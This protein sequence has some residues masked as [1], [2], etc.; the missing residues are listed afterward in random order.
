MANPR[1]IAVRE[2]EAGGALTAGREVRRDARA[3][4]SALGSDEGLGCSSSGLSGAR[5][6][7]AP[8]LDSPRTEGSTATASPG[9]A[10]RGR[11]A[12]G[13]VPLG[14][15]WR[16]AERRM[17][18]TAARQRARALRTVDPDAS[19][20]SATVAGLPRR[21]LPQ[22]EKLPHGTPGW[23]RSFGCGPT[24]GGNPAPGPG[25]RG[26]QMSTGPARLAASSA[27]TEGRVLPARGRRRARRDLR[28]RATGRGEKASGWE[29]P[30]LRSR[31]SGGRRRRALC[32][33]CREN[34]RAALR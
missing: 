22:P 26:S 15:A 2:G 8:G 18:A 9:A 13:S 16:G 34:D 30:G 12:A 29:R 24:T 27:D 20:R 21:P 7:T 10:A 33:G 5:G 14:S 23:R 3:S 32:G 6:G 11:P 17:P 28:G 4:S 31:W 19:C 1:S 25:P